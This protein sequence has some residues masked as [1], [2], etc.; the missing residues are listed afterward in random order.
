M[1]FFAHSL[2]ELRVPTNPAPTPAPGVDPFAA[3]QPGAPATA[4]M[5]MSGAGGMDTALLLQQLEQQAQLAAHIEAMR[6]RSAGLAALQHQQLVQQQHALKQQASQQ[7]LLAGVANAFSA[8]QASQPQPGS[9]WGNGV[10][11]LPVMPPSTAALADPITSSLAAASGLQPS[12]ELAGLLAAA[13]EG[14]AAMGHPLSHHVQLS[15]AAA[16]PLM[17]AEHYQALGGGAT[18]ALGNPFGHV[19]MHA[20]M[21]QVLVRA[22]D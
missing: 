11:Q 4:A 2:A 17:A 6:Q 1:C 15:P 5:Q 13:L 18:H 7:A 22:S 3:Q 8:P 20:G 10:L 19:G 9:M 14:G 21:Q 12:Y 16:A